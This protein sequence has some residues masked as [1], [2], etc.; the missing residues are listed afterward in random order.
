LR[1]FDLGVALAVDD[2]GGVQ[3]LVAQILRFG[4]GQ[5]AVQENGLGPGD[6]VGGGDRELQPDLVD[7]ELAGREAARPRLFDGLDPVLDVGVG[8]VHRTRCS[9]KRRIKENN[10]EW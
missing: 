4:V 2:R 3:Q 10:S 1:R 6:Q 8:A 5:G 7:G 9:S